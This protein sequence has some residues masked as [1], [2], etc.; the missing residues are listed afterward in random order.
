LR[1]ILITVIPP[2]LC[3]Y[4]PYLPTQQFRPPPR[5]TADHRA[6]A[7]LIKKPLSAVTIAVATAP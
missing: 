7:W 5:R 6:G 4:L 3:E 2:E 1:I